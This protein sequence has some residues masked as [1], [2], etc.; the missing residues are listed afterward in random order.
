MTQLQ[1]CKQLGI[2]PKAGDWRILFSWA[3]KRLSGG[4]GEDLHI[5]TFDNTHWNSWAPAMKLSWSPS[6]ICPAYTFIPNSFLIWRMSKKPRPSGEMRQ[7]WKL[8]KKLSFIYYPQ[9]AKRRYWLHK[10]N[11]KSYNQQTL[12]NTWKSKMVETKIKNIRRAAR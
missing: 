6:M 8:K 12:K 4:W 9:R 10:R 2:F 1:K 3:I 5:L 11:N 7:C